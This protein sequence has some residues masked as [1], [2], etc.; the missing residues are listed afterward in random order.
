MNRTQLIKALRTEYTLDDATKIAD[1]IL[2]KQIANGN[3]QC[4]YSSI[5]SDAGNRLRECD[6]AYVFHY[7]KSGDKYCR[8]CGRLIALTEYKNLATLTTPPIRSAQ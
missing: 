5:L 7:L 4:K 6:G 1:S 2:V 8:H 3:Q